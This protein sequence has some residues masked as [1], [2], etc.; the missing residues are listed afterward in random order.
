MA[1][2]AAM[3]L[4]ACGGGGGG[5]SDT[6]E[7]LPTVSQNIN[8]A[9]ARLD[10]RARNYFPAASGDTWT[11]DLQQSHGT[12]EAAVT[13]T[14]T[15]VSGSSFT[16][17]EA[18]PGGT[19]VVTYR[20]SEEGHL[21]V[22]PF[23]VIAPDSVSR[24]IGDLLEYPE[25]F[26]PIG[27]TRRIIRQ[28]VWAE[29][30]DGDGA[31]ESFRLEW[32]QIL[33]AI[34]PITTPRGPLAD[35]A[36][37]RNVLALTLQ[38][39]S[40]DYESVTITSNE[41]AWWAPGIGLVRLERT[42]EDADG[43]AVTL[44]ETLVLR[45]ATVGGQA[46]WPRTDGTVQSLALMHNDLV[47]DR[48]RNRYYASIPDSVAGN[49]NR[50]AIINPSTGAVSYSSRAIG[51]SPGALALDAA[52]DALYVGLDGTGE[53]VK[54]RLPNFEEEWRAHLGTGPLAGHLLAEDMA[55]SPADS[56]AV[57]VATYR[58]GLTP[59]QGGVVLVRAGVLQPTKTPESDGPT[60]VVFDAA[61]TK[62]YGLKTY[63]HPGEV[64]R[65]NV[66]PDGVTYDAV[67]TTPDVYYTHNIDWSA[68]GLV[69]GNL[70]VGAS[71]LALRGQVNVLGRC[72]AHAVPNR[73]VCAQ[74]PADD[75]TR[76]LAVVD[77]NT[78]AIVATP[79]Y[80]LTAGGGNDVPSQLVPGPQG[81]VALQMSDGM[82]NSIFQELWLFT[83]PALQ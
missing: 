73:L 48:T 37:F 14:V 77:A 52:D 28:G 31:P 29:D 83:S 47:Y 26:Y 71:D 61:G 18:A 78:L 21:V 46:V 60:V 70:V 76:S 66:L 25:P 9:G 13:R 10:H 54:L 82:P 15:G 40:R 38:P 20:R 41:D 17:T 74:N 57:I 7:P 43:V 45:S 34:G 8:P 6:R 79:A 67:E 75:G 80:K 36:H 65:L 19:E 49:G 22:N 30:L 64:Y 53:I 16:V 33:V 51:T 39:S 27:A 32:S 44:P 35:V 42:V 23:Q 12:T 24:F 50:I 81:Q 72:R 1:L 4:S 3:V 2:L 5:G 11:Y 69:V 56:D 68:Q 58:A 55:V 62:A 59:R 63:S